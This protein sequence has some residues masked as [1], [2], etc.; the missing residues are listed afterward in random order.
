MSIEEG[1]YTGKP[2]P[3][4]WMSLQSAHIYVDNI[5][6]AFIRHDPKNT[7]TYQKNAKIYK[8]KISDTILPLKNKILNIPLEKRWLV[9]CEG[10]F[11]Y[12]IRDFQMKELYLWPINADAQGTPKQVKKVIDS[13]RQNNISAVFCESTVSQAPAK[14]VARETGSSYG[15]VLYVDSLTDKNGLAPTYL[16]LL[17]ITSQ[18][19]ADALVK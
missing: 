18:T 19:I 13:V 3:H 16:E 10:A 4:A 5:K 14:Q 12:L 9:T 17:R 6:E 7:E 15:G 11:S 8:K 2:N 1:D